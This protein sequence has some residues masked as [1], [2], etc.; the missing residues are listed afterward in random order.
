MRLELKSLLINKRDKSVTLVSDSEGKR[1]EIVR[2]CEG[3]NYDPYIGTALAL[4]YT[5]YGSKTQFRKFVD[6]FAR[7]KEDITNVEESE[8]PGEGK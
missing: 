2:T 3:D 7:V 8:Q 4:V 1:V 6:E 5:L